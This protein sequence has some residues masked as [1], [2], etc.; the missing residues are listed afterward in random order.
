MQCISYKIVK[1]EGRNIVTLAKG[2]TV[3]VEVGQFGKYIQFHRDGKWINLSSKAW[4]FIY[5]NS[6]AITK[7]FD[8]GCPYGLTI[9]STKA[10]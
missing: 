10:L 8:S 1:M 7:S 6:D 3:N 5:N 9:N 2:L 4:R